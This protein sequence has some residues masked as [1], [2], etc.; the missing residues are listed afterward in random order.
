MKLST[1]TIYLGSCIKE[2]IFAISSSLHASE[3]WA[4]SYQSYFRDG[5]MQVWL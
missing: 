1:E 3:V 2:T 5:Q 4:M